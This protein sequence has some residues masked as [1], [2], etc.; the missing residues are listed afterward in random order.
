MATEI[1]PEEWRPVADFPNYEVSNLGRVRRSTPD[2][3]IHWAD[4]SPHIRYPS[5]YIMIGTYTKNG[6]RQVLLTNEKTKGQRLVSNLVCKAFYGPRPT[7]E[8]EAAHWDGDPA[9]D[10]LDNLRWATA[11][12]NAADRDRHGRTPRGEKHYSALLTED[13]VRQI[14][15]STLP[16]HKIAMQ[17]GVA[18]STIRKVRLGRSWRWLI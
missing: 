13:Y 15:K 9:N 12:E 18:P 5:G 7:P 8:H 16:S 4:G 6:H 3:R 10:H 17:F 1:I 2:W 14:R 11:V